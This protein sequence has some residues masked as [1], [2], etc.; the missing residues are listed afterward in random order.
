MS[1]NQDI[2]ITATI[3]SGQTVSGIVDPLPWGGVYLAN[4]QIPATFTGSSIGIQRE[5]N[6]T[7]QTFAPLG[8]VLSYPVAANRCVG[9]EIEVA[10]Q[11]QGA[12]IRVVSGSTE[13]ADRVV[14]CIFKSLN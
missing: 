3:A 8:V 5:V 6:G 9:V 10:R 4:I 11:L 12:R 1:V 14:T 7:F 2:L 13:G